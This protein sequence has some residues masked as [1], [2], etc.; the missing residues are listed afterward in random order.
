MFYLAPPFPLVVLFMAYFFQ[1]RVADRRQIGGGTV[2]AVLRAIVHSAVVIAAGTLCPGILMA[3]GE[4]ALGYAILLWLAAT[5]AFLV[6]VV[7]VDK[8]AD[9]ALGLFLG[10]APVA[11]R[12]LLWVEVPDLS[13]YSFLVFWIAVGTRGG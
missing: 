9:F 7:L 12:D 5:A 3:F 4:V 8:G 13:L 2:P 6:A 1:R 10:G 11:W